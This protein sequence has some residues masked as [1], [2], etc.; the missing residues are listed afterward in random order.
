MAGCTARVV[1]GS[2]ICDSGIYDL[3]KPKTVVILGSLKIHRTVQSMH[4][5]PPAL[6]ASA[7]VLG[8]VRRTLP[9]CVQRKAIH[10]G[11]GLIP[12][13]GCRGR[14]TGGSDS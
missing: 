10:C 13:K 14:K 3:P 2:G 11:A 12:K 4:V 9:V 8:V 6:S 1:R 5:I 7:L